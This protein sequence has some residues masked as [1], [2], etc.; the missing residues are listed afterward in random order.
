MGDPSSSPT[1]SALAF[2]LEGVRFVDMPWLLQPDHPAVMVYPP[3]AR[4]MTLETARLYALGIDAYRVAQE[5]M[6]G[7]T[8]F[9]I[10]GV[11]GRLRVNR[12]QGVRIERI[13][14]SAIYRNG[15][16]EREEVAR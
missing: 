6:K 15:A 5:W 14:T 10:D 11:T 9:D 7:E 13:P 16:I 8:R 2:D 12:A 4:P 1:A 3:P